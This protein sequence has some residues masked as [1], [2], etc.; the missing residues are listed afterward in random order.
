MKGVFAGAALW[1]RAKGPEFADRAD[2]LDRAS[3]HWL[4][5]TAGSRQADGGI[6]L[7]TIRDN[8]GHVSRNTTS[9]YLH[10]EDDERHK[11][12]VKRHRM[13]SESAKNTPKETD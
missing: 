9:L 12:T 7:R 13:N 5:H 2:E 3:A 1:L 4:R 8:I 6:D 10:A 11:E